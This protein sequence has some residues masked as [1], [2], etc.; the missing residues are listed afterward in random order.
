MQ[1]IICSAALAFSCWVR[2]SSN[3][4]RHMHSST[5]LRTLLLAT[6]LLAGHASSIAQSVQERVRIAVKAA[7]GTEA[8]L[9]LIASDQAKK[10]PMRPA[11]WIEIRS[12]VH[13][14]RVLKFEGV[15]LLV[16]S[17]AAFS[18][19]QLWTSFGNAYVCNAG[20]TGVLIREYGVRVTYD[21]FANNGEYVS[22]QEIDRTTCGAT[23]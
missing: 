9:D 20:S 12:V 19:E 14:A 7:G 11:P 3:V 17:K 13:K 1:F 4:R 16:P 23:N 15:L 22:R 18:P 5:C 10:T 6:L 8:L 2:L 21:F